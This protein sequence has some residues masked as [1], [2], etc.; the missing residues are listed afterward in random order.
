[1][2]NSRN[3]RYTPSGPLVCTLGGTGHG[4]LTIGT[5]HRDKHAV[6]VV[7]MLSKFS[8]I[9][10]LSSCIHSLIRGVA[11]KSPNCSTPT[12]RSMTSGGPFDAGVGLIVRHTM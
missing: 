7:A 9:S 12:G 10:N 8:G 5:L 1:M 11:S 2:R 6:D 4:K 3:K